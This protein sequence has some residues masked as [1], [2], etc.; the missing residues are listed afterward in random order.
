MNVPSP[1]KKQPLNT[2]EDNEFNH[3]NHREELNLL[4]GFEDGNLNTN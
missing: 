3:N 2:I 4:S 1:F